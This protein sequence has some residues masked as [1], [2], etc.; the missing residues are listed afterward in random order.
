[1]STIDPIR[2]A[3]WA[4]DRICQLSSPWRTRR[5]AWPRKRR[6]RSLKLASIAEHIPGYVFQRVMRPD[7]TIEVVY[8]SPSIFKLLG[9]EAS[10]VFARFP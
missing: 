8:C 6:T 4:P 1:M 10:E 5:I 9:V 3:R 7:G 2:D